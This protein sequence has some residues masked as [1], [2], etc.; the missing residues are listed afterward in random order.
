M[1][2]AHVYLMADEEGNRYVLVEDHPM[3]PVHCLDF[4]GSFDTPEGGGWGKAQEVA[5]KKAQELN[6]PIEHHSDLIDSWL[7]DCEAM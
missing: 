6:I 4:Y 1:T 2:K 5:E 7:T 3:P